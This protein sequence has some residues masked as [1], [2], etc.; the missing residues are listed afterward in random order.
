MCG[1]E[2]GFFSV[3]VTVTRAEPNVFNEQY[4]VSAD[5]LK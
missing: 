3:R 2:N 1:H 4:D 5:V